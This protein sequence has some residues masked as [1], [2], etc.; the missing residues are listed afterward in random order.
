[1]L[2]N[3]NE[4]VRAQLRAV[5]Y[6]LSTIQQERQLME[7]RHEKELREVRKKAELDFKRA[8]VSF[9]SVKK[10]RRISAD[11]LV[12]VGFGNGH[13]RGRTKV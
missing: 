8:Q 3:T 1:M 9:I 4:E 10:P 2:D 13:S 7:L 6:E 11:T 12:M 5:Q